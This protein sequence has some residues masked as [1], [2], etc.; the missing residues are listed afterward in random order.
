LRWVS[1]QRQASSTTVAV[2]L[3]AYCGYIGSNR[4]RRDAGGLEP[5]EDVGHRRRTVAH[6]PG[7]RQVVAALAEMPLSSLAWRS[8]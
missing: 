1:S 7:D 4:M 2:V 5:V 8:V 3:A 6:R